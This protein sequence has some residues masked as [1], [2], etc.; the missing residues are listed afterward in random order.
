MSA[1]EI[2]NNTADGTV[3]LRTYASLFE[4]VSYQ[5][6]GSQFRYDESVDRNAFTR[7]LAGRPDVVF[8]TEHQSPPLARTSAGNL[9]LGTDGKGLW[10]EARL[11]RADPDV[12]ALIPKVEA[13]N[14]TESSF[15]FRV[16]RDSWSSD[17]SERKLVEVDLDRGDVALCTFAASPQTGEYL[18]MRGSAGSEQERRAWA[19]QI[20]RSGWGG[21]GAAHVRAMWSN[22]HGSGC[23]DCDGSGRC[24]ACDGN[25]W[26][27]HPDAGGSSTLSAG[28]TNQTRALPPSRLDDL[29][30]EFI[31][32]QARAAR[33]HG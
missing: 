20:T 16:V 7:T 19:D 17:R 4:P 23:Q 18:Q 26:V 15:A 13:R 11:N 28:R 2:R 6:G 24:Q 27:P 3:T 30:R 22:Q 10:Y 21:P 33:W 14:L 31:E 9:T 29:E 1:I 5:I 12:A 32:L 25:G 8:R